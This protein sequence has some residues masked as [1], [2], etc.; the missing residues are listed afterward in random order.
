LT[1]SGP[2][3]GR[4]SVAGT[5][6][7][8]QSVT[9]SYTVKVKPDGKRGDDRIGNYLVAAGE[10]PPA[11]CGPEMAGPQKADAE[12]SDCTVNPVSNIVAEKSV[13][14]GSG[15]EVEPG[16]VLT[17]TLRFENTGQ[18]P[19]EVDHVDDLSEVLD[20]ATLVGEPAY[21]APNALTAE[22]KGKRIR[23]TGTLAAGDVDTVSYA[24][25]V[26]DADQQGDS[27]LANFLA[28][29]GE[30]SPTQ[31][32]PSSETCTTNDVSSGG[33][34]DPAE[35]PDDGGLPDTGSPVGI[36]MIV[37][38]VLLLVGGI[39]LLVVGRRRREPG[40]SDGE[41]STGA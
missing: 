30:E 28:P 20:D 13:K 17:Y 5:L 19:G 41:A 15:T 23:I 39:A 10:E 31:C 25:K 35:D 12:H 16:D 27:Q 11:D 14:P 34:D 1:A 18:G 29:A 33:A 26:K 3:N 4:I 9:V 6:I 36:G 22:V 2:S 32:A 7:P 40:L 38:A 8:G 37:A 21:E 24:V